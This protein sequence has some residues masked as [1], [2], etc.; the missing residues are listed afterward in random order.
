VRFHVIW[1]IWTS[2]SEWLRGSN[3]LFEIARVRSQR[4][5]FGSANPRTA[6]RRAFDSAEVRESKR[7]AT[8]RGVV[9]ENRV[10]AGTTE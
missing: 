6:A 2:S 1:E 10:A 9:I 4:P 8:R 5:S 7:N 3:S